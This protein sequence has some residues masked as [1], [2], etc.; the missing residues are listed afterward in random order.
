MGQYLMGVLRPHIHRKELDMQV[1]YTVYRKPEGARVGITFPATP[2]LEARE[3]RN[4]ADFL[5]DLAYYMDNPG[6]PEPK[7]SY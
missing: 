3:L 1:D 7:Q 2:S 5:Y 4:L 6:S